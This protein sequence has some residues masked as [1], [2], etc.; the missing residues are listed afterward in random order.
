MPQ[1]QAQTYP[2]RRRTNQSSSGLGCLVFVFVAI[3]LLVMLSAIIRSLSS[4]SGQFFLGLLVI[5]TVALLL[6]GPVA[7]FGWRYY[8]KQAQ[9]QQMIVMQ[10]Q[11]YA[12]QQWERQERERLERERLERE[13]SILGYPTTGEMGAADGVGRYSHFQ[14]GSIYYHGDADVGTHEIHGVIREKWSSLGREQSFLGY[15]LTDEKA[16]PDGIGRISYFQ[17]GA[18]YLSDA[19]EA[20][21]LKGPGNRS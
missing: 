20:V 18:I 5:G 19:A 10:Q 13:R 14:H 7:F 6:I 17:H 8:R 21:V 1:R 15:P 9:K 11:E 12:S 4:P 2:R 16:A 3:L